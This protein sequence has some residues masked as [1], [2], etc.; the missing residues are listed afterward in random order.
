MSNHY[1]SSMHPSEDALQNTRLARG[2]RAIAATLIVGGIVIAALE[3]GEPG[4]RAIGNVP[5]GA[6]QPDGAAPLAPTLVSP[7]ARPAGSPDPMLERLD[8]G[9]E[10]HG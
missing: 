5:S 4:S 8:H 7:A 1:D 6:V 2:L 3:T 10:Q 9:M